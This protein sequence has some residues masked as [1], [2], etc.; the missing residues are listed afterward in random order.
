M[1]TA[2]LLLV[3]SLSILTAR[4]AA[5]CQQTLDGRGCAKYGNAPEEPL[6]PAVT[7]VRDGSARPSKTRAR[8]M[9]LITTA[10]W[11]ALDPEAA[12]TPLDLFDGTT[13]SDVVDVDPA[14]RAVMLH[15]VR[16]VHGRF[17]VTMD[18]RVFQVRKCRVARRT[19]TCL[20][21]LD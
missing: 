12:A 7:Y 19:T 3:V 8:L 14:V 2:L 17:Q 16:K 10:R 6:P 9:R 15:E 21:P 13:L 20:V 18:H 5:A 1:R 11:R 4:P